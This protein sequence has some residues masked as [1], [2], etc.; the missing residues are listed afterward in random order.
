MA[1]IIRADLYRIFRGKAIYITFGVLIAF[2]VFEAIAGTGSIGIATEELLEDTTDITKTTGM[3]IPFMMASA[4]TNLTYFILPLLICIAGT[5]F[6]C[7]A[8]RNTLSRGISRTMYYF[9]K[10]VP[11][12]ILTVII[13]LLNLV[14]PI[15]VATVRNGFGGD[16][17]VEWLVSVLKPYGIQVLLLLAFACV[18]I[19]IVFLTKRTAAI[20]A[21]FI[22]F[23]MVPQILFMIAAAISPKLE[24]LMNYDMNVN[25]SALSNYSQL[26]TE[27]ITRAILLGVFYIL[28][29]TGFGILLFR[30]SDIK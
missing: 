16:F 26:A 23:T 5:D 18:G 7:G 22:A 24:G 13:Q 28:V 30:K 12:L 20:N 29:S 1:N 3:T 4:T 2:L 15:I 19:F 17:T 21:V 9:A 10:L 14:V 11:V 6:S 8:V 25:L 27:D